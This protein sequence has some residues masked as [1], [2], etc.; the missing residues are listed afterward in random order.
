M[1]ES[2][3]RG[4]STLSSLSPS[5]SSHLITRQREETSKCSAR[6]L[7]AAPFVHGLQIHGIFFSGTFQNSGATPHRFCVGPNHHRLLTDPTRPPNETHAPG[8]R[9]PHHRRGGGRLALESSPRVARHEVGGSQFTA[10]RGPTRSTNGN[11]LLPCLVLRPRQVDQRSLTCQI[12]V[13]IGN[14]DFDSINLNLIIPCV[15]S[16]INP[17][18]PLNLIRLDLIRFNQKN[19]ACK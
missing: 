5:F 3:N 13:K 19:E 17:S 15:L 7:T 12:P 1:G 4:L 16:F 18:S 10:L 8:A 6:I 9:G 2:D 14:R 11:T